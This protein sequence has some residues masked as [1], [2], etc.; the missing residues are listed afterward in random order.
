MNINLFI[1]M[2]KQYCRLNP[3]FFIDKQHINLQ[4]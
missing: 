1:D 3:I 4:K 2:G